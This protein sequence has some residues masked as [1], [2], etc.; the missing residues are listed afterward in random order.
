MQAHVFLFLSVA[1]AVETS[2]L[3]W[4][5]DA[6]NLEEYNPIDYITT[7]SNTFEDP[8]LFTNENQALTFEDQIPFDLNPLD[9]TW[10][11]SADTSGD[12]SDVLVLFNK[13]RFKKREGT[14]CAASQK[15]TRKSRLGIPTLQEIEAQ[16]ALGATGVTG[17]SSQPQCPLKD[18]PEAV[19][20]VCSSGDPNDMGNSIVYAG[21]LII[22]NCE[23]RM[24][25][26]FFG[27]F[28]FCLTSLS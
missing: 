12:C 1:G 18:H 21:A 25:D 26:F 7:Q 6:N 22:A 11:F 9:P 15:K 8:V 13:N 20:A 3:D 14:S 10:E 4:L 23:R 24:Y 27:R 5:P 19:E 2:F 28:V 16:E 17:E